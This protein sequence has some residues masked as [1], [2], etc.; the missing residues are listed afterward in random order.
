MGAEERWRGTCNYWQENKENPSEKVTLVVGEEG[1]TETFLI[2]KEY[3]CHCSPVLKAAFT[4]SF[5]EVQT[6]SYR[7]EELNPN[8]FRILAQWFY[9]RKIVVHEHDIIAQGDV[10]TAEADADSL[11]VTVSQEFYLIQLWVL[12]DRLLIRYLQKAVTGRLSELW[13]ELD[14]RLFFELIPYVYANTTLD[15]MLRW[16][17]VDCFANTLENIPGISDY[18]EQSPRQFLIDVLV[19]L[20]RNT[21]DYATDRPQGSKFEAKVVWRSGRASKDD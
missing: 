15:S 11:T 16:A 13:I 17:M 8:T 14:P 3:A 18:P 9:P 21:I 19:V 6:R 10:E 7:L 12:A 1:K 4:G 20:S 5:I 2:H